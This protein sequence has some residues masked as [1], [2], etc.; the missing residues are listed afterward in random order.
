ME[1]EDVNTA[2]R[3]EE[4]EGEQKVRRENERGAESHILQYMKMCK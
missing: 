4:S 3:C 2:G 1:R